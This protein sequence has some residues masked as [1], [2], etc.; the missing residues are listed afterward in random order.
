MTLEALSASRS[1]SQWGISGRPIKVGFES[2][3]CGPVQQQQP[4]LVHVSASFSFFSLNVKP[5]ECQSKTPQNRFVRSCSSR[6][7]SLADQQTGLQLLVE[8]RKNIS[9]LGSALF[10]RLHKIN[11]DANALGAMVTT[12]DLMLVVWDVKSSASPPKTL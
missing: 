9:E 1:A 7:A 2:W 5:Q 6:F 4:L 10:I 11:T 3:S 12:A 8:Q